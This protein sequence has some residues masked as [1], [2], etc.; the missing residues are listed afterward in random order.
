MARKTK[1]EGAPRLDEIE[2]MATK[3]IGR[4]FTGDAELARVTMER[5][6]CGS[7]YVAVS[8]DAGGWQGQLVLQRPGVRE[9]SSKDIAGVLA[10]LLSAAEG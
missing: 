8:W 5:D 4:L 3:L 7:Q 2:R 6:E 9:L 10:F 1:V